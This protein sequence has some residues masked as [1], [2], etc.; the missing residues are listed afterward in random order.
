MTENFKIQRFN[1]AGKTSNLKLRGTNKTDR[2][3]IPK[4]EKCLKEGIINI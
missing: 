1:V 2:L 4:I 3:L